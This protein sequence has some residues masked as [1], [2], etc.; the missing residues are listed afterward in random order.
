MTHKWTHVSRRMLFIWF[1]LGGLIF[2]FTPSL[3][4]TLQLAYARLFAWPLEAS[5]GLTLAARPVSH[6]DPVGSADCEKLVVLNKRLQNHVANLQAQLNEAR[7]QID[8]LA[9]LRALP[10]WDRTGFLLADVIAAPDAMFINRGRD[11]GVAVEQFVLGDLSVIGTVS[12]VSPHKAR[13]K[14]ITDPTS[15]IPVRIG[16]L[17]VPA[18]MQGRKIPLVPATHTVRKDDLVYARAPGRLDGPMV[19][20]KVVQCHRDVENPLLWD[21]TVEPVCD[22]A[23][24]EDVAVVVPAARAK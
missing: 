13:I 24:L 22:I 17:E 7:K 1:T 2:L 5:R 19:A 11:D 6:V 21:I 23:T 3:T 14:L 8:A 20:A 4:G 18:V 10:Q 16:Q 15:R 9:R 12:D